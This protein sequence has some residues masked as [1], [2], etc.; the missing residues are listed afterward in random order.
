[1]DTGKANTAEFKL[2]VSAKA[3][4]P[5]GTFGWIC[6]GCGVV[7][8]LWAGTCGLYRPKGVGVGSSDRWAVMGYEGG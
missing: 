4:Q 6:S 1:M 3:E 8:P 2:K 5:V 7:C